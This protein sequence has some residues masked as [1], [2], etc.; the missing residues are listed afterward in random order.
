[1]QKMKL[2]REKKRKS[3]R[4]KKKKLVEIWI[5]P[6]PSADCWYSFGDREKK[7]PLYDNYV[8]SICDDHS[9]YPTVA[10]GYHSDAIIADWVA[11][12][13]RIFHGHRFFLLVG[14][15]L[16][17]QHNKLSSSSFNRQPQH[18][19]KDPDDRPYTVLTLCVGS[20]CIVIFIGPE[21]EKLP[22]PFRYFMQNPGVFFVGVDMEKKRRK[23]AKDRGFLLPQ[24]LDLLPYAKK[25]LGKK[26]SP[27]G[28]HNVAEEVLGEKYGVEKPEMV[29]VSNY[30]Y[31]DLT[32]E[33]VKYA[34]IEAF[35]AF[36]VGKKVLA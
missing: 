9:I 4:Q 35:L 19:K 14:V 36:E 18:K 27:G 15:R 21:D 24:V 34:C 13:Q 7:T 17:R 8:V 12:I 28:M 2:R 6:F 16:D 31:G 11:E 20:H 5:E 26:I 3:R 29:R 25:S 10:T 1:M 22:K 30:E 33:Q 32:K 23:L